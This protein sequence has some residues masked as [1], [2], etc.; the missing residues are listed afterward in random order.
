MTKAHII[1][2]QKQQISAIIYVIK[3]LKYFTILQL[4]ILQN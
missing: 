1:I 2:L 3:V 4:Y